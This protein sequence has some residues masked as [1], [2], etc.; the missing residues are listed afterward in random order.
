[1]GA[2]PEAE[3]I[4]RTLADE[5]STNIDYQGELAGLAAERGDSAR[6]DSIDDWLARQHGDAVAWTAN[7]YRARDAA[8]LGH[9]AQAITLLR[10]TIDGGAWPYYLLN[11]PAFAR[12]AT[13]PA[14]EALLAPKN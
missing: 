11:E 13:N 6:T 4:A 8:L 2:Y 9:A 10:Q 1:M 12:L 7:F 5:D 14:F 3:R